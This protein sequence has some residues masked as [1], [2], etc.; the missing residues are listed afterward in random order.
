[1]L[2]CMTGNVVR[3]VFLYKYRYKSRAAALILSRLP[4]CQSL[5][6]SVG[7]TI[8]SLTGTRVAHRAADLHPHIIVFKMI[9]NHA[10]PFFT[11]MEY[12]ADLPEPPKQNWEYGLQNTCDPEQDRRTDGWMD[13]RM[14]GWMKMTPIE[15]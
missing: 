12:V 13:G 6:F 2:S 3:D 14:D 11:I 7:H 8:K 5:I 9:W 4:Q 10:D 15:S 1:M